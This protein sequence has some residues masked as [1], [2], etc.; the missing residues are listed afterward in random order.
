MKDIAFKE[1]NCFI[2]DTRHAPRVKE[3]NAD[4]KCIKW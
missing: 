3:R 4:T 2:T 1:R